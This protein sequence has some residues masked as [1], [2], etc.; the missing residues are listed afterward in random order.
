MT[1]IAMLSPSAATDAAWLAAADIASTAAAIG[2]N[3]R[4][5][6]GI[7]IT[8][9]TH[10]FEVDDQV[11]ARETA[12]ADM[13]LPREVCADPE[14]IS[15][16][17]DRGYSRDGGNRFVRA[18]PGADTLAIDVLGPATSGRL[19]SNHPAGELSVDLIPGLTTA[20]RLDAVKVDIEAH[21]RNGEKVNMRLAL[22]HPYAALIMKAHAYRGRYQPRDATDIWRLLVT[23]NSAG[24]TAQGWPSG[25]DA[26]DAAHHLHAFFAAPNAVGPTNAGANRREQALIRLLVGESSPSLAPSI[27]HSTDLRSA[28]LLPM[29]V[30]WV[31]G[32]LSDWK[33][34]RAARRV[35]PGDGHALRRF[36]WWQPFSRAL[37]QLRL[38]GEDGQRHTWSVDVRLWGDSNGEV[39]AQ[40]YLDGQHHA[41]SKLP[42]A[43]PVPGG[44]VE[45]VASGYG[46]KRCHYL[47]DDGADRQLVPDPAS[48]EGRRARL[49]R[50]H[51]AVGRAI[52]LA[53]V[54]VL[55]VALILGVPQ[56]VEQISQIPP[57]AENVGSYTSP[58]QLPAWLN[59]TL[60]VATLVAGT[61][62]ALRLRY[63]WLLDG[64]LFDGAD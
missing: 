3:Y 38:T 26:R 2:A 36:R 28:R 43:F 55:I 37:F 46:L 39:R 7:S 8:L 34:R 11:P 51:P 9:L 5:V 57:I 14:L 13:G 59:I 22:P 63:H 27:W 31:A 45:V 56:I 49:E 23:A 16:M 41:G 44:T 19:E 47:T 15:A 17:V 25:L 58:I 61:E 1:T 54:A 10:H 50:E 30:A 20:L 33:R 53:S 60:L 52:G 32:V 21:L 6:G 35:K 29:R 62:R 12:D 48:A 4:L 42:A 24:L 18:H 40:L 64:G